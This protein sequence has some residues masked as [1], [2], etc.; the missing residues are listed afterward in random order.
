MLRPVAALRSVPALGRMF[1]AASTMGTRVEHAKHA[2]RNADAVCFDV[3]ST[4]INV[5]GIDELAAYLGC[6]EAVA[7]MTAN[8]MGGSQPFHE[9]LAGRL[10]LM[11]PTRQKLE[12][13]MSDHPMDQVLTPGISELVKSLQLR[14]KRVYLVSGGFRQM[15]NPVADV[16]AV[17]H[18]D[19]YANNLLFAAD[20]GYAG[21]DEKEPTSRAGGKAKVVADLK[22]KHG[23]TTVVMVG[24]GATD[25]EARDIPGGAD[26]FIGFGGIATRD[27]VKAGAAAWPKGL[28]RVR[29][30]VRAG[31][32]VRPR[33]LRQHGRESP[34]GSAAAQLLRLLRARLAAPG[35]AALTPRERPTPLGAPPL[36]RLL[37]LVAFEAADSTAFDHSG[38][39][40]DGSYVD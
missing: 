21:F 6:G 14:K 28:V 19:I 33:P 9:A 40:P 30:K 4:V 29:V 31:V 8:A 37:E 16:L 12:A 17:P 10:G 7:Q 23:Y 22:A 24:D 34:L 35:S 3:D 20:G 1:A 32:G 5:E 36:P 11:K 13:M 38:A 26:A 18:S 25:M 27:A 39:P 15:I 2:L